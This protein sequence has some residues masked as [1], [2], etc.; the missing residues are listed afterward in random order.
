MI[1]GGL[2]A[3]SGVCRIGFAAK[4]FLRSDPELASLRSDP[5]FAPLSQLVN[6]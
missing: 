5:R 4:A 3:A 6:F 1:F 2:A